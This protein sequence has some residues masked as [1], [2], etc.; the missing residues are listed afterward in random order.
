MSGNF[1]ETIKSY[2]NAILGVHHKYSAKKY[3]DKAVDIT[4]DVLSIVFDAFAQLNPDEMNTLNEMSLATISDEVCAQYS[5]KK[6]SSK[7]VTKTLN[8]YTAI[9]IPIVR[10]VVEPILKQWDEEEPNVNYN[11]ITS[12]NSIAS[13]IYK[14]LTDKEKYTDMYEYKAD[15]TEGKT[16]GIIIAMAACA[17]DADKVIAQYSDVIDQII[18][19]KKDIEAEL[20]D[21]P[22]DQIKAMKSDLVNNYIDS[23]ADVY[24]NLNDYIIEFMDKYKEALKDMCIDKPLRKKKVETSDEETPKKTAPKKAA[25]KK[26]APKKTAPK[27]TFQL[28]EQDVDMDLPVIPQPEEPKKTA[29][30]PTTKLPTKQRTTRVKKN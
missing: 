23:H 27:E 8:A 9:F 21:V 7:K 29:K 14:N 15:A 18:E 16:T 6:K 10:K 13:K 19:D 11:R 26:A 12:V 5:K 22:D 1:E 17:A 20:A 3:H 24:D 25:P 30:P 4:N 28:P 2:A